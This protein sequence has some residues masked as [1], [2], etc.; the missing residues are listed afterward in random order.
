M[1][2]RYWVGGTA[3]W[4]GVALLKWALTSGGVGGQA[5]PTSSDDVFLDAS[6]GANTVT[7]GANANC[8]SLT[9]TGFTGTL[10][11]STFNIS[12]AGVG[13]L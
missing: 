6:S 8:L 4:D 3:T 11:F 7:L 13:T 5:V 1:A 2:N 10:A 12:I 9:M